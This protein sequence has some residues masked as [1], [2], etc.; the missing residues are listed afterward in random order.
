MDVIWIHKRKGWMDGCDSGPFFYIWMA[1]I[2]LKTIGWIIISKGTKNIS[3][4]NNKVP[5]IYTRQMKMG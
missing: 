1:V 2:D 3:K 4:T 5:S